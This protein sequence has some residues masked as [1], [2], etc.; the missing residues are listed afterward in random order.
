VNSIAINREDLVPAHVDPIEHPDLVADRQGQADY[1]TTHV[2]L[3][4]H[5]VGIEARRVDREKVLA[6]RPGANIPAM[7]TKDVPGG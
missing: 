1:L 6:R 7:L 5:D 3:G 2:S 4:G